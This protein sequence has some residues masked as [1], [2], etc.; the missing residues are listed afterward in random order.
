[1]FF[2]ICRKALFLLAIFTLLLAT[3]AFTTS[4]GRQAYVVT[5]HT[6]GSATRI[7]PIECPCHRGAI[8]GFSASSG[9]LSWMPRA[10]APPIVFYAPVPPAGGFAQDGGW[11]P[12]QRQAYPVPGWPLK[13]DCAGRI[14][15]PLPPVPSPADPWGLP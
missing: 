11:Y 9:A 15:R 12:W 3:A 4:R 8:P 5:E 2:A 6:L 10:P 1:M 13:P 7:L 14:N